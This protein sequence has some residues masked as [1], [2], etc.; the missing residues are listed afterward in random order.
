MDLLKNKLNS[1]NEW[2]IVIM[3]IIKIFQDLLVTLN[4]VEIPFDNYIFFMYRY[5]ESD[6]LSKLSE[7]TKRSKK[8]T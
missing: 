6:R 2:E 7:P 1:Y 4:N 8:Y 5:Q 3:K